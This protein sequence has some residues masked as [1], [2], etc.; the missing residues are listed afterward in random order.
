VSENRSVERF[1]RGVGGIG[2][3]GVQSENHTD[4]RRTALP[5]KRV[6]TFSTLSNTDCFVQ[7]VSFYIVLTA[8]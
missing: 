7:S 5:S 1:L 3:S 2:G 4:F 8:I 6:S